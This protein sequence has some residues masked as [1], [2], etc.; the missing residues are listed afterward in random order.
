MRT[1]LSEIDLNQVQTVQRRPSAVRFSD[2]KFSGPSIVV[3]ENAVRRRHSHRV[4]SDDSASSDVGDYPTI[5][6]R[7]KSMR[8]HQ[9]N[10][11]RTPPPPAVAAAAAAPAAGKRPVTAPSSSGAYSQFIVGDYSPP[12]L[13]RGSTPSSYRR[14]RKAKSAFAV[15]QIFSPAASDVSSVAFAA[16]R[17]PQKQEGGRKSMSFLRGG[18]EFMGEGSTRQRRSYYMESS[19]RKGCPPII[20]LDGLSRYKGKNDKGEW[21]ALR[22]SVKKKAKKISES[23]FGSVR[24]V[25]GGRSAEDRTLPEQHVPSSRMHFRDYVTQEEAL[26][27]TY[28]APGKLGGHEKPKIRSNYVVSKPPTLHFV[29]SNDKINSELG[30]IRDITPPFVGDRKVSSM[31]ME[32]A[33]WDST[34][35]SR[36]SARDRLDNII[37]K[38]QRSNAA[39]QTDG[40]EFVP[41]PRRERYNVDA[42]RVYSA[43]VKKLGDKSPETQTKRQTAY[44]AEY[45]AE[46]IAMGIHP[47]EKSTAAAAATKAPSSVRDRYPSDVQLEE[48]GIYSQAPPVPKIPKAWLE[49]DI[50]KTM[51]GAGSMHRHERKSKM[52]GFDDIKRYGELH[53]RSGTLVA[54][55]LYE[56]AS[57]TDNLRSL[58]PSQAPVEEQSFRSVETFASLADTAVSACHLQVLK[59]RRSTPAWSSSNENLPRS[60]ALQKRMSN[61]EAGNKMYRSRS[62]L[63]Q[64]IPRVQTP[65]ERTKTAMGYDRPLRMRAGL[66]SIDVNVTG[67]EHP[68][69][70]TKRTSGASL[71][72]RVSRLSMKEFD[73]GL[74]VAR[75][76]G[77]V[78]EE[79]SNAFARGYDSSVDGYSAFL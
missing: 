26:G 15:S 37:E 1:R 44:A 39:E 36:M 18:T 66:R 51:D 8:W 53:D 54:P 24:K 31:S 11:G 12:Q 23:V 64:R 29:A 77:P 55:A 57:Y 28:A 74:A 68:R 79:G 43:L 65:I 32:T 30:S 27:E 21:G 71:S 63:E 69:T 7:R 9:V 73:V 38:S 6:R 17:S 78:A 13:G 20:P 62:V 46:G 19:A 4:F 60:P 35:A 10:F 49:N 72:G 14:I 34:I 58:R 52:Y 76:F 59:H 41:P 47:V 56:R 33:T 70:L 45:Y 40:E 67:T 16:E 42:R 61:I 2:G 48:R 50:V 3:D 25:L 5:V 75:Q 22:I